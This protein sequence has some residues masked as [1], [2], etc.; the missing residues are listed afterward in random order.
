M[1]RKKPGWM[2]WVI[3]P[4]M[5][6]TASFAGAQCPPNIGFESGDLS[7]WGTYSGSIDINGQINLSSLSYPDI[8]RHRITKR[9][10]TQELDRYGGFP[11]T[12]PNGSGYSVQLGNNETG[13]GAESISY[14]FTIPADKFYYSIIYN[15]A[16]VLQNPSHQAFQQPKFTA[17][18][19]DVSAGSYINCSSFDFTASA[20]LPGFR[21]S[22]AQPDVL[23]KPWSP[24]TIK[25]VGYAGKTIRLEFTTNDCTQGGHFGYA[26]VDVDEDCSSP[27]KGSVL[28]PRNETMTLI[29]PYGFS[30]YRWF[31]G[32]DV[33]K[34]IG[35]GDSIKLNPLPKPGEIYAVELMPY[36]SQGCLDTVYTAIRYSSDTV[37]LKI[38]AVPLSD[39]ITAGVNIADSLITKG[40]SPG[41]IY[42]YYTDPGLTTRLFSPDS[43][44]ASGT[45]YIKATN[46]D[47]CYA[48]KP[49]VVN[50]GQVPVL[51]LAVSQLSFVRP[52][53]LDLASVISANATDVAYTF[54]KDSLATIPLSDA[55][56]IAKTGTYYVKAV[57]SYGCSLI[58]PI[59]VISNDPPVTLSNIFSPN[60]DGINDE[61]VNSSLDAYADCIVEIFNR[62]GQ[63]VF[64][65]VG[66]SKPWDGKMNGKD[67]PIAT[68]YYVIRLAPYIKPIGGSVTITR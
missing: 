47:G 44:L 8:N 17:R 30:S 33:T 31:S 14:E 5:L 3:I 1:N 46:E 62:A 27:I 4:V 61:W 21:F 57:T 13:R 40:S 25:L 37:D 20:G 59:S 48:A 64:R 19:F 22:S 54:W 42:T 15:Y 66:Y 35:T 24:V 50:V 65:S 67:L 52:A 41:L 55:A 23:Y 56:M 63:P 6:L 9:V 49:I 26:Y 34:E 43:L 12:C 45:Y 51:S 16:V 36:P 58:A 11:V 38:P 53:T 29:A 68:Y 60:G 10:A 39:C 2:R 32:N 28:C 7:H 18:V